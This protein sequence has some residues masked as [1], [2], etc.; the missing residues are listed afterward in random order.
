[1]AFRA[2]QFSILRK[3]SFAA[4]LELSC[5]STGAQPLQSFS[6][7]APINFRMVNQHPTSYPFK[8]NETPQSMTARFPSSIPANKNVTVIPQPSVPASPICEKAIPCIAEQ[9]PNSAQQHSC[10]TGLMPD[11]VNALTK[12]T[13]DALRLI[14]PFPHFRGYH[15]FITLV[16]EEIKKTPFG[17]IS[18]EESNRI[19]SGL[20]QMLYHYEN[21]A[22]LLSMDALENQ[23][24]M[25]SY[26]G[27]NV[28]GSGKSPPNEPPKRYPIP[29][30][31]TATNG[32]PDYQC[33]PLNNALQDLVILREAA[34]EHAKQHSCDFNLIIKELNTT[35]DA[36][37]HA[38]LDKLT[39]LEKLLEAKH[40]V[41]DKEYYTDKLV[42][43][44]ES[45]CPLLS[46]RRGQ[47]DGHKKP[48]VA[49]DHL[50]VTN[51]GSRHDKLQLVSN[52]NKELHPQK[53]VFED[54]IQKLEAEVQ[55]LHL[56][57]KDFEGQTRGVEA[58]NLELK[59]LQKGSEIQIQTLKAE[60]QELHLEKTELG[61]QVQRLEA[62]NLD[63][64]QQNREYLLQ[65]PPKEAS[66]G[67]IRELEEKALNLNLQMKAFES[68]V[69]IMEAQRLDLCVQNTQLEDQFQRQ[70]AKNLELEA[71]LRGALDESHNETNLKMDFEAVVQKLKDENEGFRSRIAELENEAKE[72]LKR[73]KDMQ[74]KLVEKDRCSEDVP[75]QK[76]S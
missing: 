57:K 40:L 23:P 37:R 5:K 17:G 67:Q 30:I 12:L 41:C 63:L 9:T 22:E 72:Q 6:H 31:S 54:R 58:A 55:E 52:E 70:E 15:D 69:K 18:A 66:E 4:R 74:A 24:Q 13:E 2:S 68:Q 46:A 48:S 11:H 26:R 21:E 44:I 45:V 10:E 60:N 19:I 16:N 51:T 59:L 3:T 20:R 35:I 75:D 1:M 50:T 32:L 34:R 27:A 73:S 28:S 47:N 36:A 39:I 42:A 8:G 14:I 25:D 38:H 64:R 53:K 61:G 71:I 7:G 33:P 43:E 29:K 65:E 49:Y 76:G 62:E 56:H